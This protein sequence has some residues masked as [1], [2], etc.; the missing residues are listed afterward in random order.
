MPSQRAKKLAS[1][2]RRRSSTTILR[3]AAAGAQHGA[4]GRF[5]LRD[6]FRHHH[7][8]ARREAVGLDHDRRDRKSTIADDLERDALAD[9]RLRARVERQR[10]VRVGVDVDEPGGDDLAAGV[11]HAAGR[12]GRARLDGGDAAVEHGDV[13]L[14]AGRAAAVDDVAATD[15]EVVHVRAAATAG[16][17]GWGCCCPA[18]A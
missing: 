10:E 16:A 3:R 18:G 4:G 15:Q 17:G 8:L 6:R 5:R 11:E 13:G 9:L 14:A 12:P 1:S 7:A 2:P